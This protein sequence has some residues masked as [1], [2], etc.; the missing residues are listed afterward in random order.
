MESARCGT[1]LF[2][3]PMG[4]FT[5]RYSRPARR[6]VEVSKAMV[7]SLHRRAQDKVARKWASGREDLRRAPAAVHRLA[8]MSTASVATA[9]RGRSPASGRGAERRVRHARWQSIS[10]RTRPMRRW[11]A[12]SAVRWTQIRAVH[13]GAA[14]AF[15][16]QPPYPPTPAQ[17]ARW[18]RRR[19]RR[20]ARRPATSGWHRPVCLLGYG[21]KHGYGARV[22]T[23]GGACLAGGSDIPWCYVNDE[24]QRRARRRGSF[25]KQHAAAVSPCL[26]T[27]LATAARSS[28]ATAARNA[29]ARSQAGLPTRIFGRRLTADAST[30][31]P[32][33]SRPPSLPRAQ[34]GA[35]EGARARA[36]EALMTT[37]RHVRRAL[38]DEPHRA[39]GVRRAAPRRDAYASTT[40]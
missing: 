33:P 5:R 36:D 2:R 12:A 26:P 24:Q 31:I 10:L 13:R 1:V 17:P 38:G 16:I 20:T 25:G 35:D 40:S 39:I 9:T 11:K 37:A 14:A 30:C 27:A 23:V 15:A 22:R 4:Y 29:Q 21:N 7:L 32:R 6:F 18:T 34:H 19:R 28:A 8:L 3:L